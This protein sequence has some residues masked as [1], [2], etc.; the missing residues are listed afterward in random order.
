MNSKTAC[1]TSAF[2]T[3]KKHP[4]SFDF[5]PTCLHLGPPKAPPRGLQGLLKITL[6]SILGHLGCK[7]HFL[8]SLGVRRAQFASIFDQKHMIFEIVFVL[9]MLLLL[10]LTTLLYEPLH[11]QLPWIFSFSTSQPGSMDSSFQLLF[12]SP[13]CKTAHYRLSWIFSFSTS[14]SCS[15]DCPFELL[16]VGVRLPLQTLIWPCSWFGASSSQR[17][18]RVPWIALFKLFLHQ[19]LVK[20]PI[21]AAVWAKPP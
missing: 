7:F 6:G 15:M 17:H 20:L 1:Y 5:V 21:A 2:S 13:T 8:S 3:S 4:P 11:L 9:K 10:L 16:F 12:A 18:N 19:L 14:Q